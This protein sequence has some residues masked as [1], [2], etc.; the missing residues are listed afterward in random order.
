MIT[1]FTWEVLTEIKS[2]PTL[3][4]L[5]VDGGW[6]YR[7]TTLSDGI[8]SPGKPDHFNI[9]AQQVTFVPAPSEP[10]S[11]LVVSDGV[12]V[13]LDEDQSLYRRRERSVL[14]WSNI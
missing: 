14:D 8:R 9:L 1:T 12:V 10:E 3:E 4:R 2:Y 5:P 6:L 13:D 11:R 7:T